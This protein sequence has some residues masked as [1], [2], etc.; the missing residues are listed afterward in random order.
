ML[1]GSKFL[2]ITHSN[3]IQ[4]CVYFSVRQCLSAT[5]LNDCDLFL[6]P[7]NGWETD[8]EFQNDCLIFTIFHSQ[9]CV[10]SA[11]GTNHWIPFRPSEVNAKDDF[12]SSFM[13]DFIR[14]RTFSS[15]ADAVLDAGRKLRTYYHNEDDPD[16]NI[17]A[18]L[19]EIREYYR[20]RTNKG[21]LM[22][23]SADEQFQ[24]FDD[25]LKNALKALAEK[26]APKRH[27]YGFLKK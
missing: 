25:A 2:A 22:S 7:N 23:K 13:A 12:N 27:P 24:K 17:N 18:S 26:I 14:G 15:E 3:I 1:N 20:G 10:K 8:A 11:Q 5:W 21:R 4:A 9:N 16:L 6:Y 19:Y